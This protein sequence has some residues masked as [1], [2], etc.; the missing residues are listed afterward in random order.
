MAKLD[1]FPK[2][3]FLQILK[4]GRIIILSVILMIKKILIPYATY[5]NGHKVV[6]NYIKERFEKK[7][8][9]IEIE[10]LDILDY[11]TPFMRKV[12]KG[13]FEKTM[14]AKNPIIWELIYRF[15]NHKFRSLGMRKLCYHLFDNA[16]MRAKME[17]YNPDIIISTHFF[18]SI[19]AS[20]YLKNNLIQS[21]IYTVI[22]DYEV[23]A[24]WTKSFKYEEAI[25]VSNKEM[26]KELIDKGVPK[27]KIKVFGIPLSDA[28]CAELDV[29]TCKKK[30]KLDNGRLTILF[31]GG[32]NNSSVS[33]PFLEHL[34]R[35]K[36]DFNIIFIAGKNNDLKKQVNDLVK[37]EGTK[38]IQVLGFVDGV[39]EYMTASD[40][41][42]TKP[43]GLT[44]TECLFLKKPMLLINKS[45]GQ[46]KANYK[47]LVKNKFALKASNLKEFGTYLTK[48][49]KNPQILKKM[50]DN[51]DQD[52]KKTAI[53]EL[54]SLVMKEHKFK[55]INKR[56][57]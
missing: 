5:G 40:L 35:E 29:K 9:D 2:Q 33:F 17:E 11:A 53:D 32:G 51:M 44:V 24:V 48:I 57:V 20:K 41:V 50:S 55:V 7:N 18:A 21:K 3:V 26:S 10:T 49:A 54:Y 19:L 23:H 6:A 45:A 25:I 15:Y 22:T 16:K 1:T 28:F 34:I 56:K 47:Y 38:N 14:F 42:I 36:Y 39:K 4:K 46:E 30:L 8:P 31:F 37:K 13:L 27:N 52:K 12:S 43:G